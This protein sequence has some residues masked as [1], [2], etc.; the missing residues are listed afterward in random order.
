MI[1]AVWVENSLDLSIERPHDADACEHRRAAKLH[2]KQQAFH[3]RLPFRG[4]M[5]GLRKLRDVV[6]GLLERDELAPAGKRDRIVELLRPTLNDAVSPMAVFS[7]RSPG[8]LSLDRD[9]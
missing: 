1:L 5:F 2:H 7:W 8:T 6:A 9:R 3:C 4:I